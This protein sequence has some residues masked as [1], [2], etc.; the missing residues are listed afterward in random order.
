MLPF[1]ESIEL[2]DLSDGRAVFKG[3]TGL[4]S[5]EGLPLSA[6]HEYGLTSVYDNTSGSQRNAMATLYLYLFD[7]QIKLPAE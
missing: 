5:T 7:P 2:T 4:A 3:T 1:A 6:G